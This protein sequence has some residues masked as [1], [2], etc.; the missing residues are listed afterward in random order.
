METFD[1]VRSFWNSLNFSAIVE[2]QQTPYRR[3]QPQQVIVEN[4]NVN[5]RMNIVGFAKNLKK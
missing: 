2:N 5:P 1:D 4:Q 3:Q